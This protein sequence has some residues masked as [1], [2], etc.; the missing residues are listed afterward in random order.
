MSSPAG[1][2]ASVE[3]GDHE[4][5][6]EALR[7]DGVVQ[8]RGLFDA[9]TIGAAA[10]EVTTRHPEFA[11]RAQLK[12]WF[13]NGDNRFIA[14]VVVSKPLFD[15]GLF[16]SA[17]LDAVAQGMLGEEYVVEAFGM[18]MS[19]AGAD[20][21]LRHRD[22]RPLF[23]D[24]GLDQIVPPSSMAVIMPLVPVGKDNGATEFYLGT[25]RY[26][27]A[28]KHP[29]VAQAEAVEPGDA[30]AWDFRIIHR[31]LANSTGLDRPALHYTLS[32]PF[33]FDYVNYSQ[34]NRRL[35]ADPDVIDHLG[36]RY[37]RVQPA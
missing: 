33:W 2:L 8:L 7:R 10:S 3:A 22:G 12:D 16:G 28:D 11:D 13:D 24:T 32:R 29:Q 30:L 17:H 23:P 37:V 25:H 14:P 1:T 6:L 36:E 5:A 21:Q 4:G 20:D 35:I 19:G 26:D 27:L 15:L 18:M 9:E 31:G 34:S